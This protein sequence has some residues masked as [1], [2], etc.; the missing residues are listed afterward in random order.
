MMS[1]T[2]WQHSIALMGIK[3]QT[4]VSVVVVG[5]ALRDSLCL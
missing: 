3:R 4:G 2:N 5:S 1:R